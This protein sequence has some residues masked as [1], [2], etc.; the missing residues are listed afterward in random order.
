MP[1]DAFS[2]ARWNTSRMWRSVSPTYLLSSSGPLML[3]KNERPCSRPST[4]ATFLAQRVRDGLG[5]ERLAA[6]RRAVEQDS[7]RQ[8]QLVLAEQVGVQVRQLDRVAD[9]LDLRGETTDV[10]VVDVGDLLEDELLDLGLQDLLVDVLRARLEQ[11]RVA[12]AQ[13]LREQR[14]GPRRTTRSSSVWPMT[15]ARKPSSRISMSMTIAV[16]LVG[17][18]ADDVHRPR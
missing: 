16:A 8:A 1:S 12:G 5:D 18:D 6:A 17:A 15:R 10:A 2:R 11:Q 13:L 3:R 14:G 7:L 4:S 9:L